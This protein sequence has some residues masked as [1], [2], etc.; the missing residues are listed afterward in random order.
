MNIPSHMWQLSSES[1]V[2]ALDLTSHLDWM[3]SKLYPIRERLRALRDSGD[4][5]CSL[6]GVVWTAG[7]SAYIQLPTR[8][9]EMLVALNLQLELEFAETIGVRSPSFFGAAPRCNS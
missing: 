6:V 9:M 2:A 8:L 4:I 5:R 1:H 3:L 7:T